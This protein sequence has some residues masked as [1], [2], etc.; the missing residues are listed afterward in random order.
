MGA[1]LRT[2]AG[3]WVRVPRARVR[4]GEF[5]PVENP[6]LHS[7]FAGLTV[8]CERH[9][10]IVGDYITKTMKLE[11]RLTFSSDGPALLRATAAEP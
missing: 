1:G 5:S 11:A 2:R 3:S 10:Y 8:E 4:V 6:C 7:G 9:I